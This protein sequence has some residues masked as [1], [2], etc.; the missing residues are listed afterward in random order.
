[1]NSSV[2]TT[3]R[4]FLIVWFIFINLSAIVFAFGF[5]SQYFFTSKSYTEAEVGKKSSYDTKMEVYD[6]VVN[7]TLI[8]LLNSF[9]SS[10][11]GYIFASGAFSVLNNLVR[12]SGGK[13]PE[14]IRLI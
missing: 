5:S 1:M 10:F 8:S 3:F 14:P 4:V 12:I 7:S 9:V 13:D 11:L 2:V 6:K